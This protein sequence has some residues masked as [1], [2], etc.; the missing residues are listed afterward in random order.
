M[1]F[2]R[3]HEYCHRRERLQPRRHRIQA[4]IPRGGSIDH[5]GP[6]ILEGELCIDERSAKSL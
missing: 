3:T 4:G 6:E 2:L 1:L 5:G